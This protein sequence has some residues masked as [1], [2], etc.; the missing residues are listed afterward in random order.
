MPHS[1]GEILCTPAFGLEVASFPL[2]SPYFRLLFAAFTSVDLT[3][4]WNL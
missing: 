4:D 3:V 2:S 1:G